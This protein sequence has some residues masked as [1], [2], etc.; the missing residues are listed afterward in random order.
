MS[1]HLL[2][3]VCARHGVNFKVEFR[4]VTNFVKGEYIEKDGTYDSRHER[5]PSMEM[6]FFSVENSGSEVYVGLRYERENWTIETRLQG[7][8]FGEVLSGK[9]PFISLGGFIW[10]MI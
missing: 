3:F 5:S 6:D 8:M 1:K 4:H 10:L 2:A 9:N 7:D